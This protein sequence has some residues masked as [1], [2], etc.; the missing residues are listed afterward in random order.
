MEMHPQARFFADSDSYG[1]G[2]SELA[3]GQNPNRTPSEHANPTTTRGTK[4]GG[5]FTYPKMVPLVLTHSQ[6]TCM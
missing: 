2:E 4:M 3:M 5:E 1:A 6:L